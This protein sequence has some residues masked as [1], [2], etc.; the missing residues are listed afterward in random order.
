MNIRKDLYRDPD[1]GK[2][3]GVCAGIADYFGVELWLV[4][5][6]VV[7]GF[8]LLAGPFVIVAYMAAWFILEKK[9]GTTEKH[10]IFKH[11]RTGASAF[12][13]G[14]SNVSEQEDKKVEVKAK[15][16][17]SGEPP[18]QAFHDIKQRFA[19][20]ESRLRKVETYVTS[21]E[22]QLNREINNL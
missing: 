7:T 8:F 15:V 22:F 13:K 3:A 9:P 19:R 2:I 6:L 17:Q 21:S 12:G 20:N 4:R 11:H 16:W 14:W 10:D 1:K 18:K 5:I